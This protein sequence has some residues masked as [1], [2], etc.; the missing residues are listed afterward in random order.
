MVSQRSVSRLLLASLLVVS[1]VGLRSAANGEDRFSLKTSPETGVPLLY[2]YHGMVLDENLQ[3]MRP[4]FDNVSRV[5]RRFCEGLVARSADPIKLRYVQSLQDVQ[6]SMQMDEGTEVL[7]YVALSR[8]LLKTQELPQKD[9]L[10]AMLRALETWATIPSRRGIDAQFRSNVRLTE[11]LAKS[12]VEAAAEAPPATTDYIEQCRQ[13]QVPIPP[14]WGDPQ[15][16]FEYALDPNYS[17]VNDVNSIAQVWVYTETNVPGLC[18]GLPRLDKLTGDIGLFGI[19]CQSK[20]TGKACFWDN[21]DRVTG[22]RLSPEDSK[23]LKIAAIQ[24]GSM[25]RENCTNCHRGENVFVI[26]PRTALDLSALF[27]TKPDVDW[28]SPISGQ[29]TW[30]NPGPIDGLTGQCDACHKLPE[31]GEDNNTSTDKSKVPAYCRILR[32]VVDKTMPPFQ[33]PAG[34]LHPHSQVDD[35]KFLRSKCDALQQ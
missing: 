4:T 3:V 26:H 7:L 5:L 6:A 17:F 15:W 27:D 21:V 23:N 34:W 1:L 10:A 2:F 32:Q 19:L 35:V 28:Y 24:D 20:S 29:K 18:V 14:D 11:M 16:K 8:W 12:G 33:I 13:A 25:L 30:G 31:L 22:E 9:S